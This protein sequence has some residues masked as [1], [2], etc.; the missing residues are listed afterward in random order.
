MQIT[1]ERCYTLFLRCQFGCA[2]A[3]RI[4]PL[5][6]MAIPFW[7]GQAA[8]CPRFGVATDLHRLRARTKTE[9]IGLRAVTIDQPF[10]RK[11]R[12]KRLAVLADTFNPDRVIL[13]AHA[14]RAGAYIRNDM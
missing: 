5:P 7:F 1:P 11:A 8:Q 4:R 10:S 14:A 6:A 9:F 12:G 13:G 3:D 2:Y